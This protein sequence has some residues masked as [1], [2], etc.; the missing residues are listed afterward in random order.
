MDVPIEDDEYRYSIVVKRLD[1]KQKK[2]KK[3]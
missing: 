1:I 2:Q 3:P